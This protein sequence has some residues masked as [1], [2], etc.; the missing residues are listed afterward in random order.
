M[1]ARSSS[2]LPPSVATSSSTLAWGWRLD[3]DVGADNDWRLIQ[4]APGSRRSVIFGNWPHVHTRHK[5]PHEVNEW[6]S[7]PKERLK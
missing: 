1:S 2:P 7:E 3:A 6:L 4:A 5:P